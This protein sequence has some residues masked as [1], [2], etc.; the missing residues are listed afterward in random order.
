M[1][2]LPEPTILVAL[3]QIYLCFHCAFAQLNNPSANNGING[4]KSNAYE[5]NIMHFWLRNGNMI[6]G[7]IGSITADTVEIIDIYGVHNFYKK[8]NIVSASPQS[9]MDPSVGVGLGIPYGF[10]GLN[11]DFPVYR[12]IYITAGFGTRYK[13]KSYLWNIGTNIY[14]LNERLRPRISVYYGIN[15]FLLIKDVSYQQFAGFSFGGGFEARIY[16]R[17]GFDFSMLYWYSPAFEKAFKQAQQQ[18]LT[19]EKQSSP[20]VISF[21][22]R[23]FY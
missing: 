16:Y 22:Y 12:F 7:R 21:G 1:R 6:K 3:I 17:H 23:F 5:N 18:W 9:I 4:F 19:G 2:V 8:K 20:V 11:I 14:L 15:S 10:T 13:E